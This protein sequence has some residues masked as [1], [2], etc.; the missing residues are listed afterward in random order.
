MRNFEADL[1]SFDV[2]TDPTINLPKKQQ[3]IDFFSLFLTKELIQNI[4]D[5]TNKNAET[6]QTTNWEHI[7]PEQIKAFISMC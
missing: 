5:Y 3:S 2:E 4:C 7:S 1:P 6:T